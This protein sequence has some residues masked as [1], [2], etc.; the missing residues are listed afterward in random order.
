MKMAKAK[1]TPRKQKKLDESQKTRQQRDKEADNSFSPCQ[2][3]NYQG[4]PR[5]YDTTTETRVRN[6]LLLRR[7]G[8]S[9]NEISQSLRISE[10][11]VE[12]LLAEI[13][14]VAKD[15]PPAKIGR[16][17]KCRLTGKPEARVDQKRNK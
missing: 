11:R 8:F 6:L 15:V 10:A 12:T 14:R 9:I 1:R 13:D 16:P 5:S 2:G 4:L 3:P 7:R 17:R